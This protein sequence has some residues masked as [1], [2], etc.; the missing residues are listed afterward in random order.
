MNAG[1]ELGVEIATDVLDESLLVRKMAIH[2][3][4]RASNLLC[5]AAHGEPLMT[6]GGEEPAGCVDDLLLQCFCFGGADTRP[7]IPI[8]VTKVYAV[9]FCVYVVHYR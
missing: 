3:H 9:H 7:H 8:L 2:G 6:F 1:C 5:H 4:L